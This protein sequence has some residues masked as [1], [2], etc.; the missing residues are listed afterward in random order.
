MPRGAA[1]PTPCPLQ[2]A[3]RMATATEQRLSEAQVRAGQA[4]PS[5]LLA[6]AP[7]HATIQRTQVRAAVDALF[8]HLAKEQTAKNSL[9]EEEDIFSLVR[10]PPRA[11][12][13][14]WQAAAATSADAPLLLTP[15]L[16]RH[17]AS[18]QVVSLKKIP[19]HGSPKPHRMCVT[20]R[21][22]GRPT[23]GRSGRRECGLAQDDTR[24]W[25]PLLTAV[26][27]TRTG[28]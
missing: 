20:R 3:H 5:R 25:I 2:S 8:T 17:A 18:V 28:Q 15:P 4:E 1:E 19:G 23:V 21:V 12:A 24:V 7:A 6:C 13:G 16:P 10:T 26:R 22:W 27:T 14:A 11:S 9:L